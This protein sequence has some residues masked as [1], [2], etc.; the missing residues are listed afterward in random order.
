MR[1]RKT[2]LPK[3]TDP[4]GKKVPQVPQPEIQIGKVANTD[5]QPKSE[6]KKAKSKNTRKRKASSTDAR[7]DSKKKKTVNIDHSKM[8]EEKE[9]N[10]EDLVIR[11]A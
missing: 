1:K 10:R 11:K 5:L 3:E 8:A 7:P 6:P 4:K 2:S 9:L